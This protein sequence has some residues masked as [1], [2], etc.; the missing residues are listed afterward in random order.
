[1]CFVIAST[2]FLFQGEN[3]DNLKYLKNLITIKSYSLTENEEII[4]Y[5]EKEFAKSCVEILR[6]KNKGDSKEN[7]LIGVNCKLKNIKDAII[8]SGHIDTVVANEKQ[9][10]TNPYTPIIIDDKIYGLGSIDMKSYF[11]VILNNLEKLKQLK[12]PIIIAISCDEETTFNGVIA[13][14]EKMK[15]LNIVPKCSI[16]GE[17]TDSKICARSK[18]CYEYTI[19]VTGKSCHSSSPENG[20]NAN[21]IL[22]KLTL[23]FEKLCNKYKETTTTC[24][25]ISGGE[26]T[27]IISDKAFLKFDI[28]SFSLK[29]VNLILSDINAY[30]KELLQEYKGAK[31][32][33]ENNF[34]ILALENKNVRLIKNICDK[35]DLQMQDFLGGC[36]A[37]YYQ[38]LGGDAFIYGV[39]SLKLA[40]KPNEYALIAEFEKYSNNFVDII[41][42]L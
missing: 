4:D 27:N 7:L 13:L 28:R 21:Y 42:A 1:M 31:I 6:L 35:F 20:I 10:N 34:K 2:S 19:S 30:I 40:H 29:N 36:E 37:G 22:A 32:E 14:T 18:S 17:P 3:M 8:L 41:K 26:K 16:I 11:A 12:N 39:G 15:E 24:N 23:M 33:L 25:V 38:E 5:L 9:Y